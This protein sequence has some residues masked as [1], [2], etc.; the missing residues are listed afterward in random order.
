[1]IRMDQETADLVTFTEEILNTKLHFLCG[2]S[3]LLFSII[4]CNF[5]SI[6]RPVELSSF[7]SKLF[8]Y[9]T[10]LDATLDDLQKLQEACSFIK[11]GTLEQVFSCEV[12]EISKNTFFHRTPLVTAS[13]FWKSVTPFFFRQITHKW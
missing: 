8:C 13:L 7:L 9:T 2:N 5:Q 1:M 6:K 4:V 3:Y 11:K 10:W 12:C